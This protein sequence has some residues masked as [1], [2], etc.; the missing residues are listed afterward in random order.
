MLIAPGL[1]IAFGSL[2]GLF[3]WC[4][5]MDYEDDVESGNRSTRDVALTERTKDSDS[6]I[7][8]ES[9]SI[10]IAEEGSNGYSLEMR[11]LLDS[12]RIIGRPNSAALPFA[13]PDA[14]DVAND[15]ESF[16]HIAHRYYLIGRSETAQ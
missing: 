5:M 3:S 14:S 13:L 8:V 10:G 16:N 7:A 6:T 11:P 1:L 15:D 4:R 12:V 2:F 9:E